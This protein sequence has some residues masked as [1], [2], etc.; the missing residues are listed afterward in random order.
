MSPFQGYDLIIGTVFYIRRWQVIGNTP[1][2]SVTYVM[3]IWGL[4]LISFFFRKRKYLNKTI[5][6]PHIVC[7][8]AIGRSG[9]YLFFLRIPFTLFGEH[10]PEIPKKGFLE[11]KKENQSKLLNANSKHSL[12]DD[13]SIQ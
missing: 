8:P 13:K 11:C 10:C 9:F 3:Y 4:V 1:T 12:L 6:F 5:Y 7:G 2:F